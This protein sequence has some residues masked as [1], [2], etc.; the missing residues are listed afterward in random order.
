M[1]LHKQI[2]KSAL[3]VVGSAAV[4]VSCATAPVVE[5]K[6]VV[7]PVAVAEPSLQDKFQMAVKAFDAGN[8]AEAQ[9]GFEMLAQKAPQHAQL[10]YNLGVVFEKQGNLAKAQAAYEQALK[11]APG[12]KPSLLNLGKVYRLQDKFAQSISLYE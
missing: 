6:P 4:M 8:Y 9:S 1:S 5:Q 11:L 10:H 12:H 3:S 7:A 2:K